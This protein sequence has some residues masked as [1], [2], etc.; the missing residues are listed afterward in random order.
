VNVAFV[1]FL[2]GLVAGLAAGYRVGSYSKGARGKA[3][4]AD[5]ARFGKVL[6]KATAPAEPNACIIDAEGKHKSPCK[7]YCTKEDSA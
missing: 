2:A 7:G 5:L 1:A 6:D 4:L 3:F